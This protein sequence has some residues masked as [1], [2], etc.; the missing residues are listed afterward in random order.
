M[1]ES[2]KETRE[3]ATKRMLT[4]VE[5][6]KKLPMRRYEGNELQVACVQKTS[7]GEFRLTV[8]ENIWG[9]GD[10]WSSVYYL[11]TDGLAKD[12]WEID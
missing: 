12:G 9:V 3:Q 10:P 6:G 1:S 4:E 2:T 8:G 5:P 11:G 7:S